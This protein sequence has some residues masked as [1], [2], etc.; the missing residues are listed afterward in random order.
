MSVSN[1]ICLLSTAYVR[2]STIK[3]QYFRV[4]K[5]GCPRCASRLRR[6]ITRG[7]Q[8][9]YGIRVLS[10]HSRPPRAERTPYLASHLAHLYKLIHEPYNGSIFVYNYMTRRTTPFNAC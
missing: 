4:E 2:I 8:M 1:L 10:G 5:I 6:F 7:T 9:E 3:Q